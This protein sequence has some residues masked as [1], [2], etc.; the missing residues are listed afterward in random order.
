MT[1]P[2]LDVDQIRIYLVGY[3]EESVNIT[4]AASKPI[5]SCLF[6]KASLLPVP[7]VISTLLLNESQNFYKRLVIS[8]SE[9]AT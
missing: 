2:L 3:S 5:N 9:C 7:L 1:D 4:A 8:P 6:F